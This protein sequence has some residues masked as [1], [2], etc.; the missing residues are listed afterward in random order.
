MIEPTEQR[1]RDGAFVDQPAL[2][3]RTIELEHRVGQAQPA[4]PE[5]A[6]LVGVVVEP[7]GQQHREQLDVD[8]GHARGRRRAQLVDVDLD[9][10][11]DALE[12][13]RG[14]EPESLQGLAQG[15]GGAL[16]RARGVGLRPLPRE[17]IV[18]VARL[19]ELALDQVAQPIPGS[20]GLPALGQDL[21]AERLE[22]AQASAEQLARL[23]LTQPAPREEATQTAEGLG[24]FA[25]LAVEILGPGLA[26]VEGR[27]EQRSL[28]DQGHAGELIGP[29]RLA[30]NQGVAASL[31]P[32]GHAGASFHERSRAPSSKHALARLGV[33]GPREGPFGPESGDCPAM[34]DRKPSPDPLPHPAVLAPIPPDLTRLGEDPSLSRRGAFIRMM[35]ISLGIGGAL[36]LTSGS[37]GNQAQAR[38]AIAPQPPLQPELSLVSMALVR[39]DGSAFPT[40]FDGSTTWIAGS[41]GDRYD[42]HIQNHSKGRVEVVVSVDGRDVISGKPGDYRKQRGYV[43]E[44]FGSL[45]VEGYRQSLDQI[46]AF[47]FS[48]LSDSYSARLG[49]PGNVG[50]IGV[51]AFAEK[52]HEPRRKRALAPI[53]ADP[54]PG[55][56]A[57]FQAAPAA[58][59]RMVTGGRDKKSSRGLGRDEAAVEGSWASPEP[60][61]RIGTEYGESKFSPVEEV[62]F[63]RESKK[64]PDQLLVLRYDSVDGLRARGI[65]TEPS[66]RP[67]PE[68]WREP[69]PIR[70]RHRSDRDFA[71]P[72]P[73]KDWWR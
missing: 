69:E 7:K 40:F 71:K 57:E 47:R 22:R 68:P 60:G 49:T 31:A 6:Q 25:A 5:G 30:K 41:E 62:E 67:E 51:A 27:A 58:E 39:G 54:F 43:L 73:P 34:S 53:S 8:L 9:D 42:L 55:E 26:H 52:V 46:A 11:G 48:S 59:A 1:S 16:R 10:R 35:E 50:V 2:D 20:A 56:E 37:D 4:P 70:P 12:Q 44:P 72:P 64:R 66:W 17:R 3:Q 29:P 65:V 15:R 38:K 45:I 24:V 21:V 18:G 13:H 32:A 36:L 28:A 19:G 33:R 61:N 63:K 14:R 23:A